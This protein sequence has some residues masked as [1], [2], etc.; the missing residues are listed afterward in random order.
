MLE[1][2]GPGSVFGE[3]A[4]IDQK[5]RSATAVVTRDCRLVAVGERRFTTLVQQTPY[6][7]LEIMHILANRL[8]R[9][10]SS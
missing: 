4:L 7:A 8:P 6:F 1:T 5:P 10:T 2:V 3:L 9:N